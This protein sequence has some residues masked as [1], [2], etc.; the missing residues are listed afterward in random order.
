MVE[1]NM[2]NTQRNKAALVLIESLDQISKANKDRC[3]AALKN[4]EDTDNT[5]ISPS[6]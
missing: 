1:E 5:P 2:C 3:E 4:T 6:V